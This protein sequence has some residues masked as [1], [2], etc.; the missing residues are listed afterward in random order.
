LTVHGGT[1]ESPP[2]VILASEV[3]I[4]GR[5]TTPVGGGIPRGELLER[6]TLPSTSRRANEGDTPPFPLVKPRANSTKAKTHLHQ[7]NIQTVAREH[8]SKNSR[9]QGKGWDER[10]EKK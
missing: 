6:D 9:K 5:A 4:R 1:F 7:H 10:E 3:E 2:H 8:S